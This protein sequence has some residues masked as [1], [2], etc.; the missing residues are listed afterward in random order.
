MKPREKGN[1]P[2]LG[3]DQQKSPV[4]RNSGA[5]KRDQGMLFGMP[6]GTMIFVA[7]IEVSG[8]AHV[9]SAGLEAQGV[10]PG[11]H[12]KPELHG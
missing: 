1:G 4:L 9:E 5:Q 12:K 6:P 8:C 2:A 7:L 10:K 11:W 3:S